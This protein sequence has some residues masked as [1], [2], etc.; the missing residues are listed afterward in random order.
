MH[1]SWLNTKKIWFLSI[2]SVGFLLIL[3]LYHLELTRES[4]HSYFQSTTW[5]TIIG[6]LFLYAIKSIT[7]TIPNSVLY[8]AAG[9][10]F[11]TWLAIL[12]TYAGLGVS[13]SVGYFTGKKLGGT[14]VYNLLAKRKRIK[15]FL[16]QN[17][18]DLLPLC[19][20]VRLLAL[21]FGLASLFFGALKTPFLKYAI[22]SLLGV[23]PTMLPIVFAG[24]AITNPLSSA[25][26]VPFA[27]S[28]AIMFLIFVVYKKKMNNVV[29]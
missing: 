26:L 8:I 21:P 22:V 10:L 6:L 2:I 28:L 18:D 9:T 14:K 24:S 25:F 7:M 1:L 5:L 23:T 27:I 17:E 4:V 19:F 3:L 12:V 11:P 29:V 16:T 20:L 15:L 13:L